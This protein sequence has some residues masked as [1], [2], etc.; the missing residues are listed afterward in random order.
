MN[1]RFKKPPRGE[2]M[3]ARMVL[4]CC[5]LLAMLV[6]PIYL[7]KERD[8]GAKARDAQERAVNAGPAPASA[9]V[10]APAPAVI[11]LDRFG[12][13]Y[14]WKVDEQLFRATCDGLPKDAM[15]NP[16]RDGCNPY[17]GDTSCRTVLPLLCARN[18]ADALVLSTVTPVAGFMI[19]GRA[20]ADARCVESL[21]SG[22]R[23]AHF[24]NNAGGWSLEGARAP[25][26]AADRQ[27]RVWVAINDQCA[28]CWDPT[29]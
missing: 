20:A 27:Q 29:P 10:S 7:W 28:N 9:P 23:M 16:H 11:G 21:G 2:M 3:L 22:W 25:G 4:L 26:I 5:I 12:L 18:E 14:G 15:T 8:N 1:Y 13:T 17:Q 6:V 24:H 19:G